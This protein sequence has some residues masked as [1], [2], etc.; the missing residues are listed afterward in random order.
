MA[1]AF[2]KLF[3]HIVLHLSIVC[4]SGHFFP[5]EKYRFQQ[6]PVCCAATAHAKSKIL[7]PPPFKFV[8]K[9]VASS[10]HLPARAEVWLS[11][12]EWKI[13]SI[14]NIP[15][16]VPKRATWKVPIFL[17][18][19]AL[20]YESFD[21]VLWDWFTVLWRKIATSDVVSRWLKWSNV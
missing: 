16:W 1:A 21:F 4:L 19:N 15:R 2:P 5:R 6:L 8:C 18:K 9:S 11:L 12:W 20:I 17:H 7:P 14:H 13:K 10:G 3:L